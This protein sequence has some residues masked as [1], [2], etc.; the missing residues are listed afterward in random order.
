MTSD[1]NDPEQ[2]GDGY[3]EFSHGEIIASNISRSVLLSFKP[4]LMVSWR[5]LYG[6]FIGFLELS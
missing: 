6:R 2:Y 5:I 1:E 4:F 3:D